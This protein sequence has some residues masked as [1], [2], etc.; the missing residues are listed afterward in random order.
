M[1][2]PQFP[3]VT[4]IET[5]RGRAVLPPGPNSNAAVLRNRNN[6]TQHASDLKQKFQG[7]SASAK[8][9]VAA[10]EAAN[11]PVISG[12]V[13]FVLQIPDQDDRIMDFVARKLKLEIVAEYDDGFLI[14]S[15][16]DLDLQHVLDL[17]DDFA[18]EAHGS[19][20]M[21][22]ILDVDGDHASVNRIRR[23]LGDDLMAHWPF[24]AALDMILDVSIEVAS[25]DPPR[26]PKGITSR[27]RAEVKAK[28]LAE[29]AELLNAFQQEWDD[30]RMEREADLQQLVSHYGGEILQITDDSSVEFPDSFAMRIQMSGA[31]F[32]DLIT[33]FPNLFEVC[34]P[35]EFSWPVAAEIGGDSGD[36]D[37]ELLAPAQEAPRLCV[38][39]S[40]MQENHR[41]LATAID[42]PQS[43]CFL[44]NRTDNDVAD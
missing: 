20:S 37:F 6:R 33:I 27:T 42:A 2:A 41:W 14:V 5:N 4:L 13:P 26:K 29:H 12:G 36:D 19:G 16:E 38:I 10:R 24:P 31:G 3:H 35:D 43:H 21:A 44:P 1:P 30:K 39:D 22:S 28:K 32:V 11:L 17:A 15:T 7:F 8:Q 9:S 18:R 25:R 34:V 23:I 40:G